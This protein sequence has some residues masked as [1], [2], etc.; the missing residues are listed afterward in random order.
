MLNRQHQILKH[1]ANRKNYQQSGFK[2]LHL[3][4]Q[5]E[6]TR[7][8]YIGE[9][10]WPGWIGQG[11][12]WLAFI[13]STLSALHYYFSTQEK[14]PLALLRR[15]KIARWL[16]YTCSGAIILALVILYYLILNHRFEYSDELIVGA[17]RARHRRRVD[18]NCP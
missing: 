10:L 13:T 15:R 7:M 17:T 12:I 3:F 14:N 6:I 1:D 9:Q 11:L 16:F 4:N 18:E 5:Q 8:T 2:T